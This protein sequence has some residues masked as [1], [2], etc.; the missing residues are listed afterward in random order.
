VPLGAVGMRLVLE[1][2]YDALLPTPAAHDSLAAQV[3]FRGLWACCPVDT[4]SSSLL[5]LQVLE[6]R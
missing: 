3:C 6:G 4:S 2:E 5:S 1:E